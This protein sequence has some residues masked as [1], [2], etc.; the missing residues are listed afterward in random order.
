MK[1]RIIIGIIILIVGVVGIISGIKIA[2]KEKECNQSAL[3][4]KKEYESYNN[5]E[6]KYQN[7]KYKLSKLTISD[8]NPMKSLNEKEIINKLTNTTGVIMFTSPIDYI[9]REM[10]KV[11][12][13][14]AP[15]FDCDTIYYYDIDE[16]NNEE[17]VNEIKKKL[18]VENLVNGTIIFVKEGKV[19]QLQVGITKEYKYGKKISETQ[20][21]ELSRTLKNG[22][23]SISGG[24]CER[25]KQC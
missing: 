25:E 19:S 13:E 11:L 6:I 20:K 24:M 4:F 18:D 2:N 9:S 10:I 1:K 5:E 3:K 16:L 23:N 14:I 22:F 12:L 8:N 21:K 15:S 7:K 17:L